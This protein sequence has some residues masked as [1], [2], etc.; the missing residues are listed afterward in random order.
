M[1]SPSV[2]VAQTKHQA[3]RPR[4]HLVD[5]PRLQ[6]RLAEALA[7]QRLTLVVAP[8]GWGKSSALSRQV[9][10]LPEAY[11]CAWVTADADDDLFRFVACLGAALEP[12]DL[13]WRVSPSALAV[14]ARD[15]RGIRSVV[16]E[17]VNAMAGMQAPR[18]VLVLDDMHRITD[19]DVLSLVSGL[20]DRLPA[21]W[22]VVL[23]SRHEPA[24]LPV[25]RWRA[26]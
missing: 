9:A 7:S 13:D 19:A 5:R 25:S 1:S 2:S 10:A 24:G 26:R 15:E 20:I 22:G 3:P 16:D 11:V 14:L 23:A 18:G 21:S 4:P 8:A 17:I 12:L 6:H